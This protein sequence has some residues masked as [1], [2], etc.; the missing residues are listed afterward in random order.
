M[1]SFVTLLLYA[2]LL[3]LLTSMK[4]NKRNISVIMYS[5]VVG[6]EDPM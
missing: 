6:S 2:I 1:I 5:L 3:I 4:Q